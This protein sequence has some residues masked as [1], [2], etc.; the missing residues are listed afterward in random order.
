MI[1]KFRFRLINVIAIAMLSFGVMALSD[2]KS[3]LPNSKAKKEIAFNKDS[4]KGNYSFNAIGAGGAGTEACFGVF[5]F[6]GKGNAVARL[7]NNF[8]LNKKERDV[9]ESELSGTY[10]VD[11]TGEG[12]VFFDSGQEAN[13]LITKVK[14]NI[15]GIVTN[16]KQVKIAKEINFVRKNL[17]SFGDFI[18]GVLKKLPDKGVFTNKSLEGTYAFVGFG[19]GGVAPSTI[20]GTVNFNAQTEVVEGDFIANLPG[21]EPNERIL[22]EFFSSGPFQVTK[23]GIGEAISVTTGGSSRFVINTAKTKNGYLNM[24]EEIF[25][26]PGF[27]DGAKNF[28]PAIMT[29]ISD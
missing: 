18:T 19:Y 14:N 7:I 16:T 26:V 1:F 3:A 25:F 2:V 17:G 28:S 11:N 8:G 22:F 13:L 20:T 6:D 15:G 24:A 21:I 4:I 27:L 9:F 10:S 23:D 29:R 5:T 12:V